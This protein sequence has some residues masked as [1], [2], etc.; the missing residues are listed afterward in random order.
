MMLQ[1]FNQILRTI[2]NN[3]LEIRKHSSYSPGYRVVEIMQTEDDEYIATIQLVNKHITFDI[4]PEDI[5]ADNSMVDQFSP[6][7]I[8]TLTY[9]GYLGINSPKY[10]IL[11]QRLSQDNDKLCFALKK[12]GN[13]NIILKTAADI[14]R[15]QEILANLNPKDAHIVGYTIAS[16]SINSEKTLKNTNNKLSTGIIND[17]GN[18]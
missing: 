5:L 6:R 1:K 9:L 10:K 11:A 8:R 18:N 17:K 3:I 16:E 15:E 4:K 12:R 14:L 2:K 7:D 13:K